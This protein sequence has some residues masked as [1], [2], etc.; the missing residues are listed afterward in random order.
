MEYKRGVARRWKREA[1]KSEK[2]VI[3]ATLRLEHGMQFAGDPE[4]HHCPY[5][6][7]CLQEYNHELRETVRRITRKR[8]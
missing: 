3:F 6:Q 8:Y 2:T 4:Y 5:I 1:E 7:R